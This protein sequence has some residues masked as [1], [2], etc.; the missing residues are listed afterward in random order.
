M[1]DSKEVRSVIEE[2]LLVVKRATSITGEE[3]LC[4]RQC[5]N[6]TINSTVCVKGEVYPDLAEFVKIS[7]AMERKS[8]DVRRQILLSEKRG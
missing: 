3:L 6:K 8:K 4:T 7:N 2:V 5:L 1:M